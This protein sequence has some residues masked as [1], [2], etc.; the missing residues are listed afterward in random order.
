MDNFI[1]LAAGRVSLSVRRTPLRIRFLAMRLTV[2]QSWTLAFARFDLH[3]AEGC[4]RILNT[5]AQATNRG[6]CFLPG[7]MLIPGLLA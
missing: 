4:S 3:L 6:W 5:D 1:R 2:V 7:M